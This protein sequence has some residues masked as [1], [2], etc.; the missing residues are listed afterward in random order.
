MRHYK[1]P[2]G[3]L[4]PGDAADMVVVDNLA[5]FT[6]S[7][8]LLMELVASEGKSLLRSFNYESPNRFLAPQT[9][10]SDLDVVAGIGR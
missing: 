5:D 9:L 8:P 1:L 6:I 3:L 4:Q 7:I 2:C 10:A